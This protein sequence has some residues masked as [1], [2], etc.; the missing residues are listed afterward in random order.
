[1]ALSAAMK[2]TNLRWYLFGAQAAII[3]GSA[4]LSADVDVTASVDP[5]LLDA[6]TA[7]MRRHG[8]ELLFDDPDFV[9]RTR[10]L[11]FRHAKSGLPL[12]VVLAGPGLEEDFQA[13]SVPVDIEGVLVPV[14]TPEDLIITKVLAG[15]AK[16]IEDIRSV[17]HERRTSIDVE[18]IR[19]ILRLLE[20]ALGQSDLLPVFEKQW[21]N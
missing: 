19:A 21:E 17:I 4:R 6:Y 11:P 9:L 5:A 12:D 1:H 3:W 8:F 14:I 20:Q 15:R 10:V 16:D 18:R 7:A 2:E 13:R